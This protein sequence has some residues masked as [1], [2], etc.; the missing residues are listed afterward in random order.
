M[1]ASALFKCKWENPEGDL[2]LRAVRGGHP[3]C[4]YHL[5]AARLAALWW[6]CRKKE[7]SPAAS[8][9]LEQIKLGVPYYLV[10]FASLFFRL[11]MFHFAWLR[12]GVHSGEQ[13][14]YDPNFAVLFL[15]LSLFLVG[16]AIAALRQKE[17]PTE[18]RRNYYLLVGS[19]LMIAFILYRFT[20]G[21]DPGRIRVFAD[22]LFVAVLA[23]IMQ[24]LDRRSG[25]IAPALALSGLGIVFLSGLVPAFLEVLHHFTGQYDYLPAMTAELRKTYAAESIYSTLFTSVAALDSIIALCFTGRMLSPFKFDNYYLLTLASLFGQ[26]FII[27]HMIA[28]AFFGQYILDSVRIPIIG[29]PPLLDIALVLLLHYVLRNRAE[30][31]A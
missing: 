28:M 3:Y 7:G 13:I 5:V 16:L 21:A 25:K 27:R 10:I 15:G 19:L 22:A 29:T 17:L 6:W 9:W 24:R 31:M 26:S 18:L 11:A 1:A 12:S 8:G 23:L 20:L 14:E 2:C 30:S 4:M